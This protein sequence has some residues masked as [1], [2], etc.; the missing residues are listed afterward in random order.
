MKNLF[1]IANEKK[2]KLEA[3][4]TVKLSAI[5]DGDRIILTEN[6]VIV[7]STEL[8]KFENGFAFISGLSASQFVGVMVACRQNKIAA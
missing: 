7:P 2:A 5:Q 6:G 8:Q 3:M 4:P 1:Q